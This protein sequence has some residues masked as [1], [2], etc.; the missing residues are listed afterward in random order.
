MCPY[1]NAMFLQVKATFLIKMVILT[2]TD[3]CLPSLSFKMAWKFYTGTVLGHTKRKQETSRAGTCQ[4]PGP[5][6]A[7]RSR[8][9]KRH[10][11][12]SQAKQMGASVSWSVAKFSGTDSWHRDRHTE[13]DALHEAVPLGAHWQ[14]PSQIIWSVVLTFV[15]NRPLCLAVVSS[16]LITVRISVELWLYRL[17]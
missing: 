12:T 11:V 2:A 6:Q 1:R 10:G 3:Y 7:I 14:N 4:N 8:L 17:L 5:V 16:I 13:F 9:E 15:A